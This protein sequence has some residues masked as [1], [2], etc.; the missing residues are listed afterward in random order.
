MRVKARRTYRM[1]NKLY[2]PEIDRMIRRF[3]R[4]YD[5]ITCEKKDIPLL[6]KI[7]E[8]IAQI[9]AMGDDEYRKFWIR[10]PR[11]P[12]EVFGNYEDMVDDGE[13]ESYD[14][15]EAYWKETYPDEICWYS[16]ATR[17]FNGIRTLFVGSKLVLVYDPKDEERAEYSYH[18][19]FVW[20]LE[21][22]E[23]VLS[24][25]K[26]NTYNEFVEENLPFM[27]RSG[28][29]VRNKLWNISAQYRENDL[30]DLTDA[31]I[32][33][34]LEHK[35]DG[36]ISVFERMTAQKYMN[37]CKIVYE[38]LECPYCREWDADKLYRRY[39]DNRDGGFKTLLV[40]DPEA[41]DEWYDLPTDEKWDIENPSH[42]WEVVNGSSRTSIHLYVHKDASGYRLILSSNISFMKVEIVKI[43][44]ALLREVIKVELNDRHK[45]AS[46]IQ[47][48]DNVGI[49][50]C[51][52]N[53]LG[54]VYGGFPDHDA[55][56][57]ISLPETDRELYIDAVDWFSL[58]QIELFEA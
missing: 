48:K 56:T 8:K 3:S 30:E 36:E 47:G 19:L 58:K 5:C 21:Q 6:E 20:L 35:D 7:C 46:L 28:T 26:E 42:L 29:I 14:E 43:Y 34:F 52:N 12:I 2:A 49:V 9:K 50:G 15:F 17:Y 10:A 1:D 11:G 27:Y 53:P 18:D 40:N 23:W 39:A 41:F 25:L 38:A 13:V 55:N 32:R 33:L 24:T 37:I 16:L 54:Y 45:V 57:F 44:T 22:I 51:E 31:D 4:S